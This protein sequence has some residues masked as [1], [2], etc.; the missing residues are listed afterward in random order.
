VYTSYASPITGGHGRLLDDHP[1]PTLRDGRRSAL[2]IDT[3]EGAGEES[4][5]DH[6]VGPELAELMQELDGL[7]RRLATQPTIEQAKGVLVGFYGIDAD[8]AFAVLVRWSQHT[9]TKVHLLAAGLVAAA[10][11]SCGQPQAGLRR[12]I[13]QLPNSGP[14]C[15]SREGSR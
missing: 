12:F 2:T 5:A 14:N 7:R 10:S 4:R 11:Q 13:N 3:A 9:N 8:T 6:A 15:P 1:S